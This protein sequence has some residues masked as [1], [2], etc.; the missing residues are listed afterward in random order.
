MP[1]MLAVAAALFAGEKLDRLGWVA[2][3]GSTVGAA[4]VAIGA[5][6]TAAAS[7]VQ[8]LVLLHLLAQFRAC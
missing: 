3:C 6:R 4:L 5:S 8:Q 1:V 2:L 7:G